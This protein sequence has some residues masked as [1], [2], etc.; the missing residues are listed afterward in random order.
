VKHPEH[1]KDVARAF[2]WAHRNIAK[3]GGDPDRLFIGGHSAGGHLAALLATDEQYLKAEG[4]SRKDVRG[5]IAV[6]GVYRIPDKLEFMW[7]SEGGLG[8]K[9]EL[10]TNPFD[11]VFGKTHKKREGASPLCHVC[12]GLP[13]FLIA[14]CD[15]DLPLM[16]EM[17]EE[18]AKAL[19]DKKC[20]AELLKVEDRNHNNIMFK[21]TRADD[22][23]AGAMLDFIAKHGS[24]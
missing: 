19:K 21:A 13:P 18:F 20:D 24:K 23:L 7:V 14:Y 2:A 9:V 5:V 22:P 6:S 10:Q 4:L 16:P 8:A 17:A 15:H 3:F 1:V 12:A 11:L